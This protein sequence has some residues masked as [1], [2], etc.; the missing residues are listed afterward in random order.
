MTDKKYTVYIHPESDSIWV[1]EDNVEP[2][3]PLVEVIKSGLSKEDA[4]TLMLFEA[5]KRGYI[6]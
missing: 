1:D 6:Q 4:D 5:Q 2:G 3:D